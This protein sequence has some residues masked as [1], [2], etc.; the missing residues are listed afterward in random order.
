MRS[1]KQGN[2]IWPRAGTSPWIAGVE[3]LF[4]LAA[5]EWVLWTDSKHVFSRPVRTAGSLMLACLVAVL[6]IRQRPSLRELGLAPPSWLRGTPLL[7]GAT[8]ATMLV[9]AGVGAWLGSIG[10]VEDFSHWIS[11]NW[12][13]EGL[14]QLLL[15]V[16]L[17]PRLMRI[18]GSPIWSTATASVIFG[19]LHAPNLPLVL[20]TTLAAFAWCEWFRRFPNLLA[21]WLSHLALAGTLLYCVNTPSLATLR[22]GISYLY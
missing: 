3:V 16:I 15:Q 20:L 13:L 19:L 2:L 9:L 6:L 17:V 4:L 8:L 5:L 18:L 11:R 21:V 14:Q 12:H 22:V 7:S 10:N 1:L